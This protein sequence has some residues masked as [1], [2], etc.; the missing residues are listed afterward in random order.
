MKK[1]F[2]TLTIFVQLLV[3][4]ISKNSEDNL[5]KL[6]KTV[7]QLNDGEEKK[8][9]DFK[10]GFPVTI[11]DD[12]LIL[13]QQIKIEKVFVLY[14]LNNGNLKLR[15]GLKGNGPGELLGVGSLW[16]S[17]NCN[18]F[19]VHDFTRNLLY[20]FPLDSLIYKP[21]FLAKYKPVIENN[22][23]TIY[24]LAPINDTLLFCSGA[25]ERGVYK[26]YNLKNNVLFGSYG[27]Y[28]ITEETKSIPNRLLGTAHQGHLYSN[29]DGQKLI[30]VAYFY[31]GIDFLEYKNGALE[32]KKSYVFHPVKFK[33]ISF[34][35]GNTSTAFI[36]S[37]RLGF[38]S[39]AFTKEYIYLLYSGR[40]PKESGNDCTFGRKIY[41]FDWDG[42][43]IRCYELN[44]DA[45]SI[46]IDSEDKF[47]YVLFVEDDYSFEKFQLSGL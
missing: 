1:S 5:D 40:S 36:K 41:K 28:P 24:S 45:G 20:T 44:R 22:Q 46:A 3:S 31:G 8:L 29:L 11:I 32:T 13:F 25:F 2:F 9:V 47:L 14:S 37:N 39:T 7:V 10:G 6:F 30:N 16:F 18:S 27:Q 19:I 12:S 26:F 43:P 33:T 35:N 38:V 23:G 4:C 17:K 34:P 42:I 21:T 15:F